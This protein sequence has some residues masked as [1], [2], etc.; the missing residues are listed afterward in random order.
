MLGDLFI[1][2]YVICRLSISAKP[3]RK[4]Q[5]SSFGSK[6]VSKPKYITSDM[7]TYK[8]CISNFNLTWQKQKSNQK[9]K[10]KNDYAKSRIR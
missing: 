3:C 5:E 2:K 1:L 6:T 10:W 8:N 7:I 4:I 9:L